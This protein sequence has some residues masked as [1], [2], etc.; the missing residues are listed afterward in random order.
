M[1]PPTIRTHLGSPSSSESESEQTTM[2][3]SQRNQTQKSTIPYRSLTEIASQQVSFSSDIPASLQKISNRKVTNAYTEDS[4][5]EEDTSSESGSEDGGTP[6]HIPES[7][8]AGS[9]RK[10][11]AGLLNY[12]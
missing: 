12:V 6:S 10:K 7:K 8:R 5:G 11:K 3:R 2:G 4:D 9:T 1:E